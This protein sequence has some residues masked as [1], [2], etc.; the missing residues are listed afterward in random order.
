MNQRTAVSFTCAIALISLGC[1]AASR[2]KAL[3]VF[4]DGVPPLNEP[5]TGQ[6]HQAAGTGSKATA[7]QLDGSSHGPYAA[8]M[9]HACH[10]SGATNAL[11]APPDQLCSRCHTITLDKAYMHGPLTSGGCLVC[12]EPH[13]SRYP[14]LLVSDSGTFCLTCHD[15]DTVA[16]IEGHADMNE[17]CTAC[18]DAHGSDSKF[19]LK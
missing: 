4:F 14:Y 6:T 13:S 8:R 10:E 16:K 3:T 5:G 2:H 12:H 1:S 9:C 15:A 7:P 11:V 19:L 17:D 18:H